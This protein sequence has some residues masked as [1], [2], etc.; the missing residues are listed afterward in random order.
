MPLF[1]AFFFHIH[2]WCWYTAHYKYRIIFFLWLSL[3]GVGWMWS[4]SLFALDQNWWVWLRLKSEEE[5]C[6]LPLME[7][8][9]AYTSQLRKGIK[10]DNPFLL[11]NNQLRQWYA[12]LRIRIRDP[13][14]FW[15][16]DPG[17][18]MGLFRISDSGSQTHIFEILAT[19][20]WV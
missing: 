10:M 9:S 14:P 17:S 15:P 5:L 11:P 7:I 4:W 8:C 12:V 18:G 19:T 20:F 3:V 2:C 6:H 1:I 16:L 13:V